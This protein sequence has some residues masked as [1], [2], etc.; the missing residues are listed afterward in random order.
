M[1]QPIVQHKTRKKPLILIPLI[2]IVAGLIWWRLASVSAD[3][4]QRGKQ[5]PA[6]VGAAVATRRDMAIYLTALGTVTPNNTV[7]VHSLVNGQLMKLGFVEGQEVKTGQLLAQIDPR[8]FEVALTQ[9]QGQLAHDQALLNNAQ[10][11]LVRYHTLLAQNSIPEQQVTTQEALVKQYQGTV[12]MDQ[13][14]VANAKLQLS[15]SRITA[16]LSGRV[17][18]KQVDLGNIVHTSDA[19]G[20]V[21]ITQ[22]K[23]ATVVFSIP[24]DDLGQVLPSMKTHQ[25]MPVEVW[26]RG[27]QH[28]L[29]KGELTAADN[30]VSSTTGTVNLKATFKNE[31]DALF[32]NQ[33]VNVRL[34]TTIQK[35]AVVIPLAA[36]QRGQPGT[37]VYLI[38]PDN[39]VALRVIV[40]G[41]AEGDQL[42]VTSGIAAGDRVVVDGVDRLHNGSHVI[43]AGAQGKS[44]AAQGQQGQHHHRKAASE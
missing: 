34:C 8:P 7:T 32:P 38:Q 31:D 20:V 35:Q 9:A 4:S 44:G 15:Y 17:G 24:E 18:L 41:P 43:V 42:I 23:P 5:P 37:F 29:T 28:L 21:V 13:G 10:T 1:T 30:L 12:M 19:N 27:N 25:T 16:P 36:M 11:D 39:T 14:S 26:D 33:F 22:M 40:A 6:V 2:L 3:A